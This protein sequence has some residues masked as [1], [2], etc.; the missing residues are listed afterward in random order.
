L[1]LTIL[2]QIKHLQEGGQAG[3]GRGIVGSE[4]PF[5]DLIVML[6]PLKVVAVPYPTWFSIT[7]TGRYLILADIQVHRFPF[8]N[9]PISY[10]EEQSS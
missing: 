5:I 1:E 4:F 7:T 2:A 10:P 8:T 9:S 6:L 3:V